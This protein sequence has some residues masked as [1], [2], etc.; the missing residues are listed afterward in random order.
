MGPLPLWFLAIRERLRLVLGS[1]FKLEQLAGGDA[2]A[3]PASS[4]S[5]ADGPATWAAGIGGQQWR[6][7]ARASA[8]DRH[9]Q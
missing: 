3:K 7:C 2:G 9:R 1:R 5:S 4:L 8:A 6:S